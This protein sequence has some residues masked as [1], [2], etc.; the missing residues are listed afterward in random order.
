[1]VRLKVVDLKKALERFEDED[2]VS[3]HLVVEHNG[4]RLDSVFLP[5]SRW[6]RNGRS[7][8]L[9]V[10][11]DVHDIKRFFSET[12]E[13]H[14][15]QSYERK[16]KRVKGAWR[17]VTPPPE[18]EMFSFEE[19]CDLLSS[20]GYFAMMILRG[21]DN[22]DTYEPI[23]VEHGFRIARGFKLPD[24][25][26]YL[27]LVGK[28]RDAEDWLVYYPKET[29]ARK[30]IDEKKWEKLFLVVFDGRDNLIQIEL[31]KDARP[32][33]L[34]E[35]QKYFLEAIEKYKMEV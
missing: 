3:M 2:E 35:F 6:M 17:H 1:M 26:N 9:K 13:E 19:A 5:V 4:E 14:P 21:D 10:S 15:E 22:T 28:T 34:K 25:G 30:S 29:G 20:E 18:M 33:S 7:I 12:F 32:K 31:D 23:L 27:M 24:T 8:D 16:K 11:V